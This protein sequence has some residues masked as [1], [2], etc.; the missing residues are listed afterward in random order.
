MQKWYYICSKCAFKK[1]CLRTMNLFT[2]SS[3]SQY[4]EFEK[5]AETDTLLLQLLN[6]LVRVDFV[7]FGFFALNNE[8]RESI[9][10]YC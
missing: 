2:T 3:F 9:S 1:D 6:S 5:R 7:L 8:T 10:R 4:S